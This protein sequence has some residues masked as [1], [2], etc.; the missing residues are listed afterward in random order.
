MNILTIPA[1]NRYTA[2]HDWLESKHLF[3]FADYY[4]SEN[5]HFGILRVFNDDIIA[6]HQGFDMHPHKNMEIITLALSGEI[7]HEDSHGGKATV[8]PGGVQ[9]MSA[10]SGLLHSEKNQGDEAVHL[11]QIWIMPRR[12]GIEPRHDERDFSDLPH[13]KLVPVASGFDH[14]TLKIDADAVI[15]RGI[16]DTETSWTH[17]AQEGTDNVFIYVTRG[18]LEL[19]TGETLEA[20]DQARI[21]DVESLELN[22][23]A[24]TDVVIIDVAQ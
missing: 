14:D 24:G 10:G 9:V 15:Y 22:F 21:S 1:R 11:Y 4:D 13:N 6:G 8:G 18:S 16:F 5:V 7:S 23:S 19:S 17:I 2:R 20:G 12:D 3:S